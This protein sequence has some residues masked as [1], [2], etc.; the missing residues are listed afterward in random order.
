MRKFFA[1]SVLLALFVL[2]AGSSATPLAAQ[3]TTFKLTL[4]HSSE[5]HG[6]WEPEKV[7]EALLCGIARRAARCPSALSYLSRNS[8]GCAHRARCAG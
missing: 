8:R 4:L 6:R 7:G 1:L 2:I 5:N 3:G